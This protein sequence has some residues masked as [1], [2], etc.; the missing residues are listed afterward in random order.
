M[1]RGFSRTG[2]GRSAAPGFNVHGKIAPSPP[3]T[4]R[5]R[6][7]R[8]T[9]LRY[10]QSVPAG[11]GKVLMA[12]RRNRRSL[13][14]YAP[15]CCGRLCQSVP[16]PTLAVRRLYATK[17]GS[18]T[19]RPASLWSFHATPQT[20]CRNC[21]YGAFSPVVGVLALPASGHEPMKRSRGDAESAIS[22]SGT[23]GPCVLGLS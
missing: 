9:V 8:A 22:P 1:R 2:R 16:S 10:G 15:A 6:G 3:S 12:P 21:R 18:P 19:R 20:R 7:G 5:R 23:G 13:W 4:R 11:A 14:G 17:G